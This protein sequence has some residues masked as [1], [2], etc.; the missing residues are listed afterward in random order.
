MLVAGYVIALIGFINLEIIR[1][2]IFENFWIF[3]K[4]NIFVDEFFFHDEK[5]FTASHIYLLIG[6]I[7]P[8]VS[9]YLRNEKKIIEIR[10]FVG[11]VLLG[12]GDSLAAIIGKKY[13][14]IKVGQKKTLEGSIAF[15]IS[16]FL[17]FLVLTNF[18]ILNI[19]WS[20]L[21]SLLGAI[22]ELYSP[23][24]DNLVLPLF[25]LQFIDIFY[26]K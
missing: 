12:I 5:V 6:F 8:I 9:S 18:S 20:F 14:S 22:V 16:S 11:L 1:K 2:S 3:K 25:G 15:V 23:G 17:A 24:V 10:P 7:L 19:F 4:I 26:L 13:G 21:V